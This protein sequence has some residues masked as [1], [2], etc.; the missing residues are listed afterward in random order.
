MQNSVCRKF[1]LC[2]VSNIFNFNESA[3]LTR[4]I[5]RGKVYPN[6]ESSPEMAYAVIL[7]S[8]SCKIYLNFIQLPYCYVIA[9]ALLF[10]VPPQPTQHHLAPPLSRPTRPPPPPALA[11]QFTHRRLTHNHPRSCCCHPTP[12]PTPLHRPASIARHLPHHAA[13]RRPTPPIAAPR[14]HTSP[15][16]APRRPT[17]PIAAPRR[18]DLSGPLLISK[19][20]ITVQRDAPP[21]P[22]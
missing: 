7:I 2:V 18:P 21:H 5:Q 10:S 6:L 22:C 9:A 3:L 19:Y 14:R 11:P 17:P 20:H 1:H 12:P 4:I 8:T 15:I 13:P 16:A